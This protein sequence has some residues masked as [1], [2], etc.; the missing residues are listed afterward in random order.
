MAPRFS[1]RSSRTSSEGFGKAG[2]HSMARTGL[3]LGIVG[4]GIV[5]LVFLMLAIFNPTGR[6]GGL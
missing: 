2:G 3:I 1:R 6:L 4:L 5:F